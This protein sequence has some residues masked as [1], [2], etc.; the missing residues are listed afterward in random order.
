MEFGK[1]V[2]KHR[3]SFFRENQGVCEVYVALPCR[4][5]LQNLLGREKLSDAKVLLEALPDERGAC[6]R[7]KS[8]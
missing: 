4:Q 1:L 7:G 6:E 8:P 2:G 5:A 3:R